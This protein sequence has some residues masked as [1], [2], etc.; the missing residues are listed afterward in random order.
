MKRLLPLLLAVATCLPAEDVAQLRA[1]EELKSL[2]SELSRWSRAFSLVHEAVAPSVVAIHTRERQYQRVRSPFGGVLLREQGDEEV[3]EGSGFVVR[4][5]AKYSYILTNAHVVLKT[6]QHQRFEKDR[7]GRELGYDRLTVELNDSREIDADYVGWSV[8]TDLAIIRVPLP[9]LTPVDWGDS[10]Q[11]HVGDW[12]V[13]LGYPLGVGYSASSGI[14]SATDRSTGIYRPMGGLESFLQTDAAINPGTSGGPLVNLQGQ[15]VG[16]NA[17]IISRTGANIGL[18]FAIAANLAKRVAEDLIDHGA[19]RWPG[20]GIEFAAIEGDQAMELGLPRSPALR[21]TGVLSGSPADTA[22]VKAGDVLLTLNGIKTQNEMQFRARLSSAYIG[23]AIPMQ[24]WRAKE[25]TNL[26]VKPIALQDIQRMRA[27]EVASR[28]TSLGEF[29]LTVAPDGQP[30]L[31]VVAV[32]A[33]GLAAQA[34]LQPGDRILQEHRLGALS[35]AADAKNLAGKREIVLQVAQD[36][37][38]LWIR[39]RR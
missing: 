5:D 14:I 17:N 39:M 19:V 27:A 4:S 31:A 16:V 33:Q 11:A 15:I 7:N 32:D 37:R 6:D 28:G 13:A 1:K 22:G 2:G 36:G 3:G 25:R 18:G 8:E 35:T 9:N 38:L 21:V 34:G 29:G 23:Q 12:V 10:D 30:G 26:T 20:I 24:V